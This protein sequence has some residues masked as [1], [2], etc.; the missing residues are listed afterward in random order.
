MSKPRQQSSNTKECPYCSEKILLEAIKCKHCKRFIAQSS[1]DDEAIVTDSIQEVNHNARKQPY[2]IMNHNAYRLLGLPATATQA[3]IH[4][5]NS[6]IRRTLKIGVNKST[7]WDL[8]WLGAMQRSEKDLQSAVGRLTNPAQRLQERMFWFSERAT[9]LNEVTIDSL[10]SVI[11]ELGDKLEAH[12]LAL[13]KLAYVHLIDP[14]LRNK[15]F[16]IEAINLWQ[17]VIDSDD[18]WASLL[19]LEMEGEFEPF[20]TVE[21]VESLKLDANRLVCST[22]LAFAN[23]G[24]VSKDNAICGQVFSILRDSKLPR[25]TFY[26]FEAQV[27]GNLEDEFVQLCEQIRNNSSE[28]LNKEDANSP[29]NIRICTTTLNR[30]NDEAQP[31]LNK[32]L[33]L[34]G[35]NSELANRVKEEAALCLRSIA[36]AFTWADEFIRSQEL[37]ERARTI[38]PKNSSI[39]HRILEDLGDVEKTSEKQ[40]IWKNLKPIK[41]APALHTIN[42]VGFT[43]Y[44]CTDVDPETKSYLA[45]YYF[46]FFFIPIFPICRYRVISAG[47]GSYRFLGK[48]PL[49]TGHKW[50]I[51][52]SLFLIL[53]AF[54]WI[55]ASSSNSSNYSSGNYSS[56]Y[57]STP[58]ETTNYSSSPSETYTAPTTP[59]GTSLP[60]SESTTQDIQTPQETSQ[61]NITPPTQFSSIYKQELKGKIE[62]GRAKLPALEESYNHLADEVK[63]M[64]LELSQKK[65][66]LETLEAQTTDDASTEGY[67][68][69]RQAYNQLIEQHNEALLKARNAEREYNALLEEDHKMVQEYNSL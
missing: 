50:H 46:V 16:W 15:N 51:G 23:E 54:L 36:L 44:G 31:F 4:E 3:S 24:I 59:D 38:A 52:I 57:S 40:K 30:F 61:E 64:K 8:A 21:E 32:L 6:S 62:A 25:N 48:A 56:G 10:P 28:D 2:E 39:Y 1:V 17:T 49:T 14:G 34:S 67:E 42:G 60:T 11:S 41:S 22:L 55:L 63:A 13:L 47:D 19:D 29:E 58:T 66:E 53:A 5:A 68:A 27:L 26:E 9:L 12:D 20:A 65:A 45:T 7:S 37:L 69:K 43:L 18:Y 33:N 35:Q